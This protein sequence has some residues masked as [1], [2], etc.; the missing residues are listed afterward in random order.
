MSRSLPSPMFPGPFRQRMQALALALALTLAAGAPGLAQSLG[1]LVAASASGEPLVLPAGQTLGRADITGSLDVQGD[2]AAILAAPEDQ[3]ILTVQPGASLTLSGVTL[4][5]QGQTQFAIYVDGGSLT[6]TDCRIEGAFEVAIYVAAGRL[7][8]SD[9][10]IDGGLYGIQAAAGAEVMM[11]SVSLTAQGDTALRSDGAALDLQDLTLADG[12]RNGLIAI[13]APQVRVRGLTI[14]GVLETGVWLQDIGE[15]DLER[16]VAQ[17]SGQALTLSGGGAARLDGFLLQGTGGALM[18]EAL[19]GPLNLSRGRLQGGEG[20]TTAVLRDVTDLALEDVRIIGGETGL[21][22]TGPLSTARL[23]RLELL[24]Q[25]GTGLFLDG[26]AGSEAPVLTDLRAIATG[27]ALAAYFRDSG[28]VELIR[29]VL[30]GASG[31]PFGTEGQASPVFRDSALIGVTDSPEEQLVFAS[32]PD[33]APIFLPNGPLWW[34]EDPAIGPGSRALTV[35]TLALGLVPELGVQPAV[36]AF[37]LGQDFAPGDLLLA[38]DYALPAA[39]PADPS[40]GGI[41]LTL[42]PPE[43]GWL[44]DPFAIRVTLTGADGLPVDA[45]PGDFPFQVAAGQYTLALDGRPAGQVVVEPETPLVLPLPDAPFYAWRDDQGQKWRG[46]ALY[47]RPKDE[48]AALL[49]G[50]RP[51]RASEYWGYTPLFAPRAGADRA[52]AARVIAEAHARL[53]VLVDDM[54]KL[55]AAEAWPAFNLRWLEADAFLDI[56]A[57]FGTAEDAAWLLSLILP[58][59]VQI[60]H[61]DSAVMI[62][63]RLGLLAKGAALATAR[64]Q[65]AAGLPEDDSA[66]RDLV[67]LVESL[68]RSGLPEGTTLLVELVQRLAEADLSTGTDPTGIVE[69]SRLPPDQAAGQPSRFLDRFSAHLQVWLDGALPADDPAP[70]FLDLWNG[71]IAAL[72]HEALYAPP[73]TAIRRLP[74]PPTAGI[75]TS[76]WAFDDPVAVLAGP[77]G[78]TGPPNPDRLSG[79]TYR[80]PEYLCAALAYRAS[81]DRALRLAELREAVI[82]TI[83]QAFLDAD[84]DTGPDIF[85]QAEF[86]LDL[87]LGECALSDPVLNSF[88]RNAAGEEAALFDNLD[89]E[90]LWWLRRPRSEAQLSAFARGEEYPALAGHSAL[91]LAEVETLL[92]TGTGAD[93]D[94]KAAFL[95]RH[96]LLSDAFQGSHDFLTFGSEHRQFRLRSDGGNGSITIA[97][98]LDIR[99]ILAEGKLIVA[100]RHRI[101]SPDFGGLAAM[102]T[103]PDRAPYEADN[104][105]LMFEAVT[106]DHAGTETPMTYEGSSA[107]GVHFFA[108]PHSGDLSD[109]TLHLGMRFVDTTWAIDIPL[110]ASSLARDLRAKEALQ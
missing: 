93:S 9:C 103:E 59:G 48:L 110:W 31:M 47:L 73:G 50:F 108:L 21:Y 107:T 42:A 8:V 101:E 13:S 52:L 77:L 36:L 46:P 83:G 106:L 66:R 86:A 49:A 88:G 35:G 25:T 33:T 62:E 19:T 32:N 71:T 64:Q 76:A 4:Q 51:M 96:Q 56:L 20:A 100:I 78:W 34:A 24:G 11:R 81:A 84:P 63:T 82:S 39:A 94:L 10:K 3:A 87:T 37:G 91:S 15:A 104:R 45:W 97:G 80:F 54:A 17:V 105:R 44:W 41:E 109:L 5:H 67:R 43:P 85:S 18:V 65:L 29:A 92:A 61:L 53:P 99:P 30:I 89:Y 1:D 23:S 98:Y 7:S 28:P 27:S 14:S 38:L 74:I 72:V 90:P 40:A 95:A 16:V 22:L 79:W 2:G 75:G 55:Q 58:E 57:A 70:L 26:T 68:A 102:I 69:L 60:N 6:L 12:G